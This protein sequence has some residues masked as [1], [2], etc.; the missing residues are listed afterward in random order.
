MHSA[1]GDERDAV[2]IGAGVGGLCAAARLSAQGMRVTVVERL[3][4]I[5]GRFGTRVIDGF[6]LPTGAFMIATDDPLAWTFADL[7]IDFPV[8]DATTRPSYLLHGERVE[9]GA[10]GG[11][12]AITAAAAARDGSDVDALMATFRG[13]LGAS[14]PL[15]AIP[16]PDWLRSVGAG[17]TVID[18]FEANT[19]AYLAVNAAEVDAAGYF[20]YLRTAAGGSRYGVPPDGA[21]SVVGALAAFVERNGGRVVL[22][23]AAA[24][25]EVDDDERVTGVS[26]ND[27]TRVGAS[28]VI[29]DVGLATTKALLPD[30]AAAR[31]PDPPAQRNAPGVATF[32]ASEQPFFDDLA[33]TV[34]GSRAVCIITTPTLLAPELAPPGW[35][36]TE[37]LSTFRDSAAQDDVQGEIARHMADVDDLLPGWRERGRLLQTATYRG[38]WPVARTWHGFDP[39]GRFP[40]RGLA[41]VGDSIK[42]VGWTGVGA[43]AETAKLAVEGLMEVVR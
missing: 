33:I 31:V 18:V 2:V 5:G 43:S 15:P 27:G 30:V 8:R 6:K 37:C 19:R 20:A 36:F 17:P 34:V 26:L 10:R 25:I 13:A 1:T 7:G 9:I 39:T 16:L 35:H 4:R 24:S 41:L 11:L 3:R 12:R 21:R 38:E 22:G 28:L 29:S 32:I 42:A 14:A 23:N 40:I